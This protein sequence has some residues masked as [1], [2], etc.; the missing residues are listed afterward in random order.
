MFSASLRQA[1]ADH[2][3]Q[4]VGLAIEQADGEV[5]EVHQLLA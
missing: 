2:H 3:F 5:I 4:L 1:G